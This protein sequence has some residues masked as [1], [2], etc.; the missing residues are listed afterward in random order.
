LKETD[1]ANLPEK[2]KGDSVKKSQKICEQL[3]S[4]GMTTTM[5]IE[6]RVFRGE[7]SLSSSV[8]WKGDNISFEVNADGSNKNIVPEL[9]QMG[10]AKNKGL[11]RYWLSP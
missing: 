1:R 6:T 9:Y 4:E 5:I 8:T 10:D 3:A 11:G 7:L 2:Y